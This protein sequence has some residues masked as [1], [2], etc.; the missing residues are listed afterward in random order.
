M[1]TFLKIISYIFQPL[2]M[3]LYGMILLMQTSLFGLFP[4]SY[5]IIA[6]AGTFL[7][8][9]ILPAL[10]ILMMMRRG[11]IKDMFISKQEERTMPYLFSMLSYIFWVFFLWRTLLF[12][13]EFVVMA[14]GSVLSVFLMVIINLKWKISAHLAGIGGLVGGIFG[15]S[16][17][18]AINPIY[19]I[20]LSII[21]SG[22]VAVSRIY[23]KAHTPLQTFAGFC[24]GFL[25]VFLPCVL[26][27]YF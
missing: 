7:F 8:T 9:A 5:H 19:I 15:A 14:A 2:L 24:M 25:C 10:P 26:F 11:Q 16:Y 20:I 22:L 1:R 6:I 23:L 4:L 21:V 17:L 18:M 27:Q 3:P 12:P 13:M